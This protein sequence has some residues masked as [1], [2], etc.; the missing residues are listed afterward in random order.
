MS[1]ECADC[2][3]HCLDCICMPRPEKLIDWQRVDELLEAGCLGTEIASFFGMHP[4]TFYDRVVAKYN[5]SFTDYSSQKRATGEALIREAQYKKAI[6]KLDNSMLIWLG[7]QRLGQREDNSEKREPEEILQPFLE[8]MAQLKELQSQ[9]KS[10][11]TNNMSCI[12]STC[13]TGA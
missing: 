1:G 6:K 4:N 2:G 12:K 11:E 7:K 13:E 9:R 8:I 5:M 10:A 3:E